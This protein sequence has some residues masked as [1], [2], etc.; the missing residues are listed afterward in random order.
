MNEFAKFFAKKSFGAFTSIEKSFL[1]LLF[2]NVTIVI[3]QDYSLAKIADSVGVITCN[4][5][6][7]YRPLDGI[8]NPKYKLLHFLTTNCFCREKALAFNL[9]RCCYLALYLQLNLSIVYNVSSAN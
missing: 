8:T 3:S 9:D 5:I 1:K 4:A 6:G 7:L 2:E